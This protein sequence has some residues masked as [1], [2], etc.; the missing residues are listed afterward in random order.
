MTLPLTPIADIVYNLPTVGGNL[1]SFN[2]GLV[3][4]TSA[5]ISTTTRVVVYS[6]LA[7]MIDAGFSTSSEEYLSATRYFA[8]TSQPSQI[9]IGRW[10]SNA[11]T[12][13]E[14]ITDARAKNGDWYIAYV[15]SADDD[16][17][18]AIAGYVEALDTPYSQYFF[19]SD[20]TTVLNGESGNLFEVLD[21][22]NYSRTQGFTALP[23]MRW[24]V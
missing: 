18:E 11:E 20:N 13:L 14:A 2:L 23:L 3:L 1:A 4:G 10:D 15:P 16:D 9:A 8:A 24:P 7:E 17:H 12:A 22:L 21:G 6:S 5:V 19:Q